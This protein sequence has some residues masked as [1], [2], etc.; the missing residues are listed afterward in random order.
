M[1]VRKACWYW[2][3]MLTSSALFA[4]QACKAEDHVKFPLISLYILF[5]YSK[6]SGT[7]YMSDALIK[8]LDVSVINRNK[9]LIFK[10][11]DFI[12]AE[13]LLKKSELFL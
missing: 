13:Q 3:V 12:T 6:V 7:G 2:S 10:T 5:P 9:E 11:D 8:C 4:M 1:T